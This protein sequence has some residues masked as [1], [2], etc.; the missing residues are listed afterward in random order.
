[1][2]CSTLT[3]TP[4]LQARQLEGSRCIVSLGLFRGVSVQSPVVQASESG[5]TTIA[6]GLMVFLDPFDHF[7]PEP[8]ILVFYDM[9]KDFPHLSGMTLGVPVRPL[10]A[11]DICNISSD[12]T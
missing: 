1:M 6:A 10:I 7:I 12:G 4:P 5:F 9:I 8:T 11:T 2:V 3:T